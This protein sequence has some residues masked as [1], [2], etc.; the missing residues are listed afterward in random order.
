MLKVKEKNCYPRKN[1]KGEII[2]YRFY[3]YGKEQFS[4]KPI[5]YTKTWKI[6][7][8][9]SPKEIELERKEFE[10]QFIKECEN[11]SKGVYINDCYITFNEF[12]DQWLEE[13]R[14]RG[15]AFG[16]YVSAKNHLK[17]LKD[18][19]G[20]YCL[21]N[22]TPV[23]IQNFYNYLCSRTYTKELITVKQSFAELIKNDKLKHYQIAENCG[24]NRLSLRMT[25][26]TGQ[27]VS[28]KTAR[29]VCCYFKVPMDKYFN[30]ITEKVKYSSSTNKDIRTALV[31]ILNAAKKR[32]LIEQNYATKE[33][34]NPISGNV[35]EKNVYN[36]EEAK[37]FLK[38]AMSETDLRKQAVFALY[39]FLGL[40]NAE[41]CGLEW[42]DI[43]LDYGVLRIERNSLYYRGIGVVTKEPK[44]KNSKRTLSMPP[45]LTEILRNYKEWWDIQK[46]GHGD[47]WINSDRLLLQD[48]GKPTHPCTPR[49][50]LD[51][52]ERKNGLKH[53]PPHS[54]RHTSITLQLMAG[55]PIKAV[56][57]RAGHADERITLNIY[58]HFLKEEDIRAAE[59]FNNYLSAF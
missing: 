6:P 35:K 22:I 17:I 55:V 12:A 20:K 15:N 58:T 52:F 16:S 2:S 46:T 59:T 29:A 54:L 14:L 50:W 44:T 48:N 33:Y 18:Y 53:I 26:K 3:Y 4:G 24:L 13:I 23:L 21:K 36:K 27:R 31:M 45:Q 1:K 51:E 9:L 38:N 32:M 11:K 7:F 25:E 19:F 10:I 8:N 56:S 40:R 39:L 57:Q 28:M 42:K 43:D 41:I 5:Q 34:T 49:K 37:S 47:L 30:I